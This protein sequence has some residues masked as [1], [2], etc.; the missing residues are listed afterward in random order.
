MSPIL[1]VVALRKE[2]GGVRALDGVSFKVNQHQIKAIIGPNGAG[3]TTLFNI[4]SGLYFP[5]SGLIK[6]ENR[7]ITGLK[8]HLITKRGICRTFQ[9]IQIFKNMTVLENVMVGRHCRTRCEFLST[10]MKLKRARYEE[11]R[12]LAFSQKILSFVGLKDRA[13][14]SVSNLTIQEQKLLEIARALATEP[15]LLLLDEPAAGL[16]IRETEC[17]AELISRIR[18]RGITILLVEHD[19]NVVME[20]SDEVIV[21]NSG[22]VLAEGAPREIQ[23]NKEVIAVYLG[24]G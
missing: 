18:E 11:E 19:M 9:N 1:E 20:I 15:K 12:I 23:N 8:P 24:E 6:F 16:S 3:K 17:I 7:E 13:F 10:L 4:I 2:F 21:L 5:T 14:E 22:R